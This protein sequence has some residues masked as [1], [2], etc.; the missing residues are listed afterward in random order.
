MY[1]IFLG[2]R[3]S[4]SLWWW[5]YTHTWRQIILRK[6]FPLFSERFI[7]GNQNLLKSKLKFA[8]FSR[9]RSKYQPTQRHFIFHILYFAPDLDYHYFF[10][11]VIYWILILDLHMVNPFFAWYCLFTFGRNLESNFVSVSIVLKRYTDTIG[12]IKTFSFYLWREVLNFEQ[13]K[14]WIIWWSF[15]TVWA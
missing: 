14:W 1:L 15:I 2:K 3:T 8:A 9:W 5:C 13:R 12:V 4:L 10:R 7:Y 11:H 6:T